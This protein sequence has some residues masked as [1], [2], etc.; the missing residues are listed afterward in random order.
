MDALHKIPKKQKLLD[1]FFPCID[2]CNSNGS[3][4]IMKSQNYW[5]CHIT[6]GCVRV[7]LKACSSGT[8]QL[9]V[10]GW[11]CK[12]NGSLREISPIRKGDTYFFFIYSVTPFL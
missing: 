10:S 2:S 4:L 1:Q 11:T 3:Y 12:P 5:I 9:V 6:V 8:L 7:D